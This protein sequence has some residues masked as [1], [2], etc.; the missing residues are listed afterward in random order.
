MPDADPL[1]YVFVD[2]K[3]VSLGPL[4]DAVSENPVLIVSVADDEVALEGTPV[5]TLDTTALYEELLSP[6]ASPVRSK[7]GVVEPDTLPPSVR[8]APFLNH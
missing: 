8:V 5:H 6:A 7:T 1:V 3:H 2:V 4:M